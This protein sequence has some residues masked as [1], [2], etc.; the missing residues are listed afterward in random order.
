M[1]LVSLLVIV[2]VH[3]LVSTLV[4]SDNTWQLTSA[5]TSPGW[6]RLASDSTGSTIIIIIIII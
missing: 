3:L 1:T 2:L 6:S 4:I 5:P